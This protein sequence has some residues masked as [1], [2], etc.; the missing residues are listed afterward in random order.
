MEALRTFNSIKGFI[1]AGKQFKILLNY[2]E[3]SFK[4]QG[5]APLYWIST[6]AEGQNKGTL[7]RKRAL[8]RYLQTEEYSICLTSGKQNPKTGRN[9]NYS[10][11]KK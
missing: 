7:A 4:A 2:I 3:L 8:K 11:V 5:N 6:D 9:V 1:K 10:R